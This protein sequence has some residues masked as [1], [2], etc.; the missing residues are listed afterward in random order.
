MKFRLEDLPARVRRKIASEV[1]ERKP[2]KFRNKRTEVDGIKFDSKKEANRYKVLFDMNA[3]G[4]IK[5][6][7]LQPR[8]ELYGPEGVLRGESGRVIKYVGDFKYIQTD[9]DGIEYIVI[10]DVKSPATKT[11][12]YQLKKAIM[13]NMGYEITE[14]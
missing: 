5:G 12:V 8:Y 3:K 2:S 1:R 14:V 13:R 11:A 9:D 4:E 10:E 7:E 6:L